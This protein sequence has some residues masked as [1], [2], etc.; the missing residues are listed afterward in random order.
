ML[1]LDWAVVHLS[2]QVRVR[3]VISFLSTKGTTPI[4]RVTIR[5]HFQE[6]YYHPGGIFKIDANVRKLDLN[7]LIFTFER[8]QE[9]RKYCNRQ[10][11]RL[12]FLW[13]SILYQSLTLKKCFR[14]NV[15]LSVNLSLWQLPNIAP[16][17]IDRY[18]WNSIS[19]GPLQISRTFYF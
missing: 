10:K 14:K 6:L 7:V 5:P 4:D 12:W 1:S 17:P 8:H 18:R 3:A 15:H 11:I 2:H 9:W 16:K 19:G 13:I